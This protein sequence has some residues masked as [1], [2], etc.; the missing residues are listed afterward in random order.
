MAGVEKIHLHSFLLS[1]LR[2]AQLIR[3]LCI[4]CFNVFWVML[5]ETG[6]SSRLE[7][8]SV[9]IKTAER[10]EILYRN[11]KTEVSL[12]SFQSVFV[13]AKEFK[14]AWRH[15][16]RYV[17]E[18]EKLC[19]LEGTGIAPRCIH[20]DPRGCVVYMS[21]IKGLTLKAAFQKAPDS[22]KMEEIVHAINA[23]LERIHRR[24]IFV[25][26]ITSKNILITPENSI[27]FVDFGDA[28]EV[29]WLPRRIRND[30][31]LKDKSSLQSV[32][33]SLL[34]RGFPTEKR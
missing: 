6:N 15:R 32:L 18:N 7:A 14:G 23:Q 27:C 13:V 12:L 1:G 20:V 11:W 28:I 29:T 3:A 24:N 19:S 26:D 16:L 33:R 30:F 8:I 10:H 34:S 17:I 5:L 22:Q 9:T 4:H 21:H 31:Y 2:A 25:N